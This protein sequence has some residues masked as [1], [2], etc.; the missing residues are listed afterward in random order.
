MR[1]QAFHKKTA[2]FLFKKQKVD[3]GIFDSEIIYLAK[4]F[5]IKMKEVPV[6]WINNP[7]SKINFVKCVLFDP[8]DLIKIRIWDFQGR[9]D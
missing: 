5:G 8:I 3:G 9:Y 6:V 7:D 2:H 1:L 4:K